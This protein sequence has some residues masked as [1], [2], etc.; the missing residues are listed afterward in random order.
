MTL[1]Y[2]T[3]GWRVWDDGNEYVVAALQLLKNSTILLENI[4]NMDHHKRANFKYGFYC[5]GNS[6]LKAYFYISLLSPG[7]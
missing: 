3:G 6:I 4:R 7:S 5:K 1:T 2:D